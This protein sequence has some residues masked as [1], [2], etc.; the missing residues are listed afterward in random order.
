MSNKLGYTWYPKDWGNSES[1][2]ELSLSERGMYRELI[3]LSMLNDNKTEVKKSVWCR[4]FGVELIEL[5]NILDHLI[6]LNLIEIKKEVLFIPSCENRI[7]LSRGGKK[8]KPT[9]KALLNLK[10]S[11][12]EP[13]SEPISEQIESKLNIKE[14]EIENKIKESFKNDIFFNDLIASSQ[15]IET[16]AMQ[17]TNKFN[18]QQ[19]EIKLMEFKVFCDLGFDQKD[20]KKDFSQHFLRWLNTKENELKTKKQIQENPNNEEIVRYKSNVNPDPKEATRFKFEEMKNRNASGGYIYT[21][22]NKSK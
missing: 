20:S 16:T 22:L 10:N 14:I 21:E 13:I 7:N 19:V 4:K 6:H 2:F 11:L 8:S 17:S 3:D 5:E 18:P 12:S 9:P 15:W 1:V